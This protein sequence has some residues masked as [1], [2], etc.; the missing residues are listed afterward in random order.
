MPRHRD[1]IEEIEVSEHVKAYI[2]H[3]DDPQEPYIEPAGEIITFGSQSLYMPKTLAGTD[4]SYADDAAMTH[5]DTDDEPDFVALAKHVLRTYGS[6]L[7]V[8]CADVP[9]HSGESR[10]Y[11]STPEEADSRYVMGYAYLTPEQRAS[12]GESWDYPAWLKAVLD[13]HEQWANG[14][15]YGYVIEIDGDDD[16]GTDGYGDSCWASTVWT[17]R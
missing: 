3:D 6:P 15:C 12:E 4:S 16:F 7:Y 17:T 13:E 1:A 8:L 14:Y 5:G 10:Y 2:Y 9:R 11:V